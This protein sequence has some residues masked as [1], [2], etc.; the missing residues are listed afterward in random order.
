MIVIITIIIITRLITNY[1][2]GGG[3]GGTTLIQVT[4]LFSQSVWYTYHDGWFLTHP[5]RPCTYFS[6]I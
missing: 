6:V 5:P 1:R 2:G 3:G 4:N